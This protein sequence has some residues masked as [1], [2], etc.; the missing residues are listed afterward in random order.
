[1][2]EISIKPSM[3]SMNSRTFFV[4]EGQKKRADLHAC[5]DLLL[6]S[7]EEEEK[8]KRKDD[9][10]KGRKDGCLSWSCLQLGWTSFKVPSWIHTHTSITSMV[11]LKLMK[12]AQDVSRTVYYQNLL[13]PSPTVLSWW[14]LLLFIVFCFVPFSTPSCHYRVTWLPPCAL[15]EACN[16][17]VLVYLP[18]SLSSHKVFQYKTI[19]LIMSWTLFLID[20]FWMQIIP[21]YCSLTYATDN[22]DDS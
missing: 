9:R 22:A 4:M 13:S 20:V 5:G 12:A 2:R 1:M 14:V 16:L 18:V 6:P 15:Y 7:I 3:T 8:M 11:C 17:F 19:Y 21:A 10:K